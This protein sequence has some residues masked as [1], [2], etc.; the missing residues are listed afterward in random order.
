MS[1]HARLQSSCDAAVTTVSIFPPSATRLPEGP[2]KPGALLRHVAALGGDGREVTWQD[3]LLAGW[4]ETLSPAVRSRPEAALGASSLSPKS[5][6]L[7]F[8]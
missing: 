1:V 2:P 8:V 6:S 5:E 7:E 3:P 4:N